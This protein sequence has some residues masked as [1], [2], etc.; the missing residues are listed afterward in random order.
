[1]LKHGCICLP[2]DNQHILPK[3][4]GNPTTNTKEHLQQF[5]FEY[6]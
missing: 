1:M 4:V 6:L 5:G 3:N 2:E